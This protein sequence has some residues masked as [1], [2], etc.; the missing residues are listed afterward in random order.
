MPIVGANPALT[1]P[2]LLQ[3]ASRVRREVTKETLTSLN[4]DAINNVIVD[5]INDAVADIYNRA[6][7]WWQKTSTTLT[8]IAGQA[9]YSLPTDFYRMASPIVVGA[10]PLQEVEYEQWERYTYTPSIPTSTQ[11]TPLVYMVDRSLIKFYPTPSTESIALYPL[12]TLM[13]IKGPT[14][15]LALLTDSASAPNIPTEF[16]EAVV[17]FAMSRLKIFLQYDDFGIDEKRYEA[18]ISQQIDNNYKGVFLA[19]TRPRSWNSANFG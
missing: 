8:M 3:L 1:V 17:R 5:S 14:I 12:V 9:E 18:L 13:Y 4:D 16:V 15:R 11:G 7:W 2:T 10:T 19:R 6:I